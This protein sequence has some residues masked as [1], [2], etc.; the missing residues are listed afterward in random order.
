M[1]LDAVAVELDLVNPALVGWHLVDRCRQR[2]FDESGVRRFHADRHRLRFKPLL[3]NS[4][5]DGISLHDP[6]A[7]RKSNTHIQMMESAKK[8][9]GHNAT[10]GMYC[11]RRRRLLVD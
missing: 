3:V 5:R 2:G 6:C 9:R 8:W 10:N 4:F 11:S 1:N 7:C